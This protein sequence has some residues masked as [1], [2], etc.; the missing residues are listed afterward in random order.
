MRKKKYNQT[1]FVVWFA[2]N[3]F[4]FDKKKNFCEKKKKK[5]EK[6]VLQ[7]PCMAN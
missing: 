1:Q 4:L 5:K 2:F 3:Q 6:Y 7:V